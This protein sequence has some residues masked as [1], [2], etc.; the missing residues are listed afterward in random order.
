MPAKISANIPRNSSSESISALKSFFKAIFC[1]GLRRR[2]SAAALISDIPSGHL[3]K[4]EK[5]F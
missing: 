5:I 1:S 2:L 3:L 4:E